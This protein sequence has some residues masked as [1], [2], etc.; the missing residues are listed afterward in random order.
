MHAHLLSVESNAEYEKILEMKSFHS[1]YDYIWIGLHRLST[2]SSRPED[3]EYTDGNKY[4]GFSNLLIRL[5]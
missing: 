4:K 1:A 3:F 2:G 5:N